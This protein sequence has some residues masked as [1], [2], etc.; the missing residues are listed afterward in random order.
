MT[1]LNFQKFKVT[2]ADEAA[3]EANQKQSNILNPGIYEMTVKNVIVNGVSAKDDAWTS[4]KIEFEAAGGQTRT[5]LLQVPTGG[6]P[7]F[8]ET[9]TLV[10]LTSIY[11]FLSAVGLLPVRTKKVDASVLDEVYEAL[12]GALKG[13][14]ANLVGAH[15]KA[16]LGYKGRYLT[17]VE[18]ADGRKI[19]LVEK[20]G[21][22]PVVDSSGKPY[23]YESFALA[24][25]DLATQ[26]FMYQ[27][28]IDIL[29]YSKSDTANSFGKKKDF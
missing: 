27:Q 13:D 3:F 12:S 4:V 10:P 5:G 17:V 8:G 24:K 28:F 25:A 22:T 14:L 19:Q 6:K 21:S 15:V 2:A 9:A 29:A 7:T 20:D 16:T 1:K 23:L 26:N 18:S 11:D